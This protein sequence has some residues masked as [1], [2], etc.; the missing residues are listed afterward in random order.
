[1]QKAREENFEAHKKQRD[2]SRRLLA[3]D[4]IAPV[5]VKEE[6]KDEQK[7]EEQANRDSGIQVIPTYGSQYLRA[8]QQEQEPPPWA[9]GN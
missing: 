1:M 9:R 8:M 2:L 4:L 3:A 5:V 6:K 7:V